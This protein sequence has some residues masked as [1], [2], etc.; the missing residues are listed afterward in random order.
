M[1]FNSLGAARTFPQYEGYP[2]LY[3]SNMTT[4]EKNEGLP[5]SL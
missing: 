4:K 1:D 5:L 3:G 2:A